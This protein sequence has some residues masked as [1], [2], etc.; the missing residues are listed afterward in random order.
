MAYLPTACGLPTYSLLSPNYDKEQDLPSTALCSGLCCW[1]TL[2]QQF[3]ITGFF[4]IYFLFL[5][6]MVKGVRIRDQDVFYIL[7]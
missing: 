3:L 4:L 1:N 2:V 5:A 6:A 7:N